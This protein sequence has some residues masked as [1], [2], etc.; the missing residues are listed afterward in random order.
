MGLNPRIF[1][2][3]CLIGIMAGLM[4]GGQFLFPKNKDKEI[5]KPI[6][7]VIEEEVTVLVTPTPDGHIYFAS[8]YQNGTRLLQRP[9]S[10]IRYNALGTM[11]MKVTTIVYDYQTFEKLHW[12]NPSTY[13]YVE[14]TPANGDDKFCL[15]FIRVFMDDIAGEDTR[16]WL[17]NR[18]SFA[19]Y[20]ENKT[21]MYVAK[22]YPYQL[23][24][25]ELEN[26]ATFDGVTVVQAFKSLREYTSG[27][28]ARGYAGEYNDE[29]Y[30]L[31]G[32]AS[33]AIDGFLIYEI[34]KNSKPENLLVLAQLH[35]FGNAQWKLKQ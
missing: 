14:A 22:E 24:F 35:A 9:F 23:R 19:I 32:G 21:K 13:K 18:S 12:F 1:A 30:Y 33:N 25:K 31:R 16:M 10:F 15:I 6:M 7:V 20:D 34:P 5:E 8:E 2:F 17:F 28:E 3:I 11:D 27:E 26:K 4:Y 29:Q